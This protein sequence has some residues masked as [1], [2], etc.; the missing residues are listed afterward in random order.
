MDQ[1]KT[2]QGNHGGGDGGAG[3]DEDGDEEAGH[4]EEQLCGERWNVGDVLGKPAHFVLR[5]E[6]ELQT[7]GIL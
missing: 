7:G 2:D 4:E 3:V 5:V 6:K 1:A